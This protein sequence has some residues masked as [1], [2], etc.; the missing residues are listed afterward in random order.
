MW[1][2]QVGLPEPVAKALKSGLMFPLQSEEAPSA[3]G[4]LA[5]APA[6]PF[7]SWWVLLDG[8]AYGFLICWLSTFNCKLIFCTKSLCILIINH[9]PTYHLS[10]PDSL[11][12]EHWLIQILVILVLEMVAEEQNLKGEFSELVLGTPWDYIAKEFLKLLLSYAPNQSPLPQ[13]Y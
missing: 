10:P 6:V 13:N 4:G 7:C 8:L 12:V 9:L 3:G 5:C 1:I 2:I 11:L